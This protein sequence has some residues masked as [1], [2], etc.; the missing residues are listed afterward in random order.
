ML[1]VFGVHIKP[2]YSAAQYAEAWLKASRLIQQS[3]GARRGRRRCIII[4]KP[5]AQRLGAVQMQVALRV[6]NLHTLLVER[7]PDESQH[8]AAHVVDA[9]HR[10]PHPEPQFQFD[11]VVTEGA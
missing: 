11:G 7:F 10:V 5:Y 1:F 6:G 4:G 8:I 2:G 9:A 3:P